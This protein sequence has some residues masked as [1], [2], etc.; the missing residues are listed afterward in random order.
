MK[1]RWNVLCLVTLFVVSLAVFSSR[2][3]D[4]Q[5]FKSFDMDKI[6]KLKSGEKKTTDDVEGLFGKPIFA[7]KIART[8]EGCVEM[9]GYIEAQ[10][11]EGKSEFLYVLFDENGKVCKVTTEKK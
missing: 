7:E 4:A 3:A 9:W 6:N 8:D 2:P 11:S 5:E 10:L 1:T